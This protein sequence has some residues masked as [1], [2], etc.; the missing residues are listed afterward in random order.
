VGPVIQ[1]EKKML[2]GGGK[3]SVCH[4]KMKGGDLGAGNGEEQYPRKKIT[5]VIENR[6]KRTR[7]GERKKRTC[8][9]G[10]IH[11]RREN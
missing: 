10:Q 9:E 6:K 11:G 2:G 7:G 8:D 3:G 1:F 4:C 5:V